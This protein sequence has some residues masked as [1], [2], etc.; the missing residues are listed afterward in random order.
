MPHPQP[1]HSLAHAVPWLMNPFRNVAVICCSGSYKFLAN[2]GK[3]GLRHYSAAFLPGTAAATGSDNFLFGG[4][5]AVFMKVL[6]VPFRR[7]A[8]HPGTAIAGSYPCP[9]KA[10]PFDGTPCPWCQY[11]G[12]SSAQPGFTD[13]C[14]VPGTWLVATGVEM[15]TW[16]PL[17]L[18]PGSAVSWLC[19][20]KFSDLS[21]G[22]MG[23]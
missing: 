7:R 10:S 2:R 21:R 22:K 18:I 13:G 15:T 23:I 8:G 5:E 6:S 11:Q 14:P 1:S 17:L 4:E 12:L 9:P 19:P 16:T 20:S 3:P